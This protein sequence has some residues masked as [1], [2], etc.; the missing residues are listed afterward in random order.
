MRKLQGGIQS[1]MCF[2][3][4][5]TN[6]AK[7][8]AFPGGS[9]GIDMIRPGT[10]KSEQGVVVLFF[11]L[12]QVVLELAP[13]VAAEIVIRKVLAFNRYRNACFFEQA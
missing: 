1:V 4:D 6:R 10:A 3:P 11:S 8:K 7:A 5:N 2:A 12:Y 9:R 13:L